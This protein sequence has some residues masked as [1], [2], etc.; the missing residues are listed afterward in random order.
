MII[1]VTGWQRADA[2]ASLLIGVLIIPRTWKLLRESVDVLLDSTPKGVDL[3]DVRAHIG[4]VPH[5][6]AVR[7]VHASSVASNLPVLTAHVVV[8][9]ECF[10]NGHLPRPPDRLQQCLAGD[11]DVEHSTFQFEPASHAAHEHHAAHA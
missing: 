3:G 2:L 9:D 7:D 8:V 6:R 5:V 4:A 11:F 10:H 1:A